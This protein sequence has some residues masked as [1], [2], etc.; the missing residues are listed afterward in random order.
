MKLT[1]VEAASMQEALWKI[2]S[3]LGDNTEIV[4]T[5]T[6]R[7]GGLFGLGARE[8]VEVYVTDQI[9]KA[10]TALTE[11]P[12]SRLEAEV[13]KE[14]LPRDR[15][16]GTKPEVDHLSK[17]LGNLRR[18]IHDLA[19]NREKSFEHPFL[20]NA[21]EL[22]RSFDVDEKL[23]E[24]LVW[25]LKSVQ[26]PV[27]VVPVDRV[28][29]LVKAQLKK[30]FPPN[31]PTA[32][33]QDQKVLVL[34]GATG[35]GKTT[36]VAK[37]AARAKLNERKSVGLITLD[38]FRIAAVDQL[39]KYA[40]IIGVPLE[41]VSDPIEFKRAIKRFRS[42]GIQL[43]L[44]DTAGRG[45]R[46]ELKMR[47][48]Q[49]FLCIVPNA[50]V[51]LVLSTIIHPRTMKNVAARFMPFGVHRLVLTKLDETDSFGSMVQPLV[52]INKPVSFL[53][54]GQNVPDD[55]MVSDPDRLADLVFRASQY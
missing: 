52:S 47:E 26:L 2:R 9:K 13:P 45:Q 1:R 19:S 53:T 7:R 39:Q 12:A 25:D 18:E 48:L 37:M 6:F 38:T 28:R 54:D 10:E 55:I 36:T 41:V 31:V 42:E 44:V 49:E 50:E 43:T 21:Y 35:V 4:G 34:I 33:D 20:A 8:V 17:A 51:H 3:T 27:G 40:N 23:A 46:D 32:M 5:R 22:L 29:A 14:A 15:L 16:R 11:P 24:Q 30:L